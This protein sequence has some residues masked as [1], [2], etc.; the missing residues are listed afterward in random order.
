[1]SGVRAEHNGGYGVQVVGASTDRPITGISTTGNGSYG[2]GLE[3]QTGT[4]HHRRQPP[5]PTA[6]AVSS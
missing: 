4:A 6:A 1:M 2:I 5:P 3:K